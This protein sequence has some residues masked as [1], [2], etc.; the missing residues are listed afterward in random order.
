MREPETYDDRLMRIVREAMHVPANARDALLRERCAP[1]DR[2]LAD[3]RAHI[4]AE[5]RMT[6]FLS[7]PLFSAVDIDRPFEPGENL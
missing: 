5:Q 4:E 6:G 1:D 3:A 2:L 7:A